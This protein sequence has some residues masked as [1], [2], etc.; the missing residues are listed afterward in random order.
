M[1]Q[2]KLDLY[3]LHKAEYAATGKPAVVKIGKAR[4][5]TIDGKGAPGSEMFVAGIGVLY[6]VAFTVKM[7]RKFAG[8]QDYT[9]SK[10]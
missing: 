3:K 9:V 7:T 8:E 4:Y 1:T 2:P 10:L 5:L 6:G